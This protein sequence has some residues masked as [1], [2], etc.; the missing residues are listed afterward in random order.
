M[1]Y[2]R[3][4]PDELFDCWHDDQRMNFLYS[5]F[6]ADVTNNPEHW[7]S[8]MKFWKDVISTLC[9]HSTVVCV[10]VT[11][12]STWVERDGRRPMGLQLVWDTMVSEGSLSPAT[13]FVGDLARNSSWVG[14]GLNNF[15]R[16]PTMW[17]AGKML[18]PLKTLSPVKISDNKKFI[19]VKSFRE[20]C[21]SLLKTMHSSTSAT[22]GHLQI[23]S[24]RE[25]NKLAQNIVCGEKELEMLLLA[26]ERDNKV[27]L[28]HKDEARNSK[29]FVKFAKQSGDC[30]SPVNEGDQ[31][32]IQLE[33][34]K[35]CLEK[36]IASLYTQQ[37]EQHA[38]AREFIRKGE[39]GRAINALRQKQRLMLSTK[40]K[41]SSL[42]NIQQ[43]LLRLEQCETD[44]MVIKAYKA[45]VAGYKEAS[46]AGGLT[47]EAVD[48]TMDD[49]QAMVDDHEQVT[50][51]L[52]T[53]LEDD[54]NTDDLEQELNDLLAEDESDLVSN[55][56][57]AD[58]AKLV[59]GIAASSL[60]PT[61]SNN[62]RTSKNRI[63]QAL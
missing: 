53:S 41:E 4:R 47:M 18:S 54:V 31:G 26:L 49:V 44:Q 50:S 45:G 28:F 35:Q 55:Q 46:K 23:I 16:K 58:I 22:H 29:K 30:V 48:A 2:L 1:E 10:D 19:C 9:A 20:K 37:S 7:N 36:Q 13:E 43:L 39:R 57:D 17:M 59:T 8:K 62:K 27:I 56:T 12:I 5:A 25:L 32:V 63:A 11:M 21:Q 3:K 24:H 34:T 42:D 15:V 33:H 38:T 61:S 51:A 6:P 14:W 52:A 40:R 60:Q